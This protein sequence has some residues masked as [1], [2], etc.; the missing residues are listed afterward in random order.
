M[1]A[2]ISTIYRAPLIGKKA[3]NV[4]KSLINTY[5]K[6]LSNNDNFG[7]WLRYAI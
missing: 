7:V 5:R 6:S 2:T 1:S 3:R 4:K